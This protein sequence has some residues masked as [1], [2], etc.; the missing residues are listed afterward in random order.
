VPD[1]AFLEKRRLEGTMIEL[2]KLLITL[3]ER[4]PLLML[5][6]KFVFCLALLLIIVWFLLFSGLNASADFIYNQF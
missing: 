3:S 1:E 6:F 5:A 4:Y 2:E